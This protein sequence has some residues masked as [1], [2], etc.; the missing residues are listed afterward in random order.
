MEK[1]FIQNF[2]SLGAVYEE[3]RFLTFET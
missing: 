1:R 2:R 3:I